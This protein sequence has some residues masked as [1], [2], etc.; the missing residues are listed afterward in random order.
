MVYLWYRTSK[1]TS[2]TGDNKGRGVRGRCAMA[3]RQAPRRDIFLFNSIPVSPLANQRHRQC[4]WLMSVLFLSK[5]RASRDYE[6]RWLDPLSVN[7]TITTMLR[8]GVYFRMTFKCPSP[9]TCHPVLYT[10][11]ITELLLEEMSLETTLFDVVI[12]DPTNMKKKLLLS[13]RQRSMAMAS[14]P[15][16]L[17]SRYWLYLSDVP[18]WMIM[19]QWQWWWWSLLESPRGYFIQRCSLMTTDIFS[20]N[21][22]YSAISVLKHR[23]STELAPL[24]I[25]LFFFCLPSSF[26]FGPRRRVDGRRLIANTRRGSC[27]RLSVWEC[28][29][30]TIRAATEKQAD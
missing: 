22:Y 7:Q 26:S 17:F 8:V 2:Q 10:I 29:V 28:F 3:R 23:P 30:I 14:S 24:L 6:V 13:L 16:I 9:V 19:T 18:S 20:I 12:S 27:R 1:E 4:V 15:V 11:V 25:Y 5:L 21:Y